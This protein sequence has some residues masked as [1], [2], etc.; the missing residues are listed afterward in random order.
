[1]AETLEALWRR[2]PAAGDGALMNELTRLE[3]IH[4][5]LVFSPALA[6]L[7]PPALLSAATL[8][9]PLLLHLNP[10]PPSPVAR[11]STPPLFFTHTIAPPP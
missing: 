4:R 6:V 7:W 11:S 5:F 8:G 1:M 10:P 3:T 9:A 2:W